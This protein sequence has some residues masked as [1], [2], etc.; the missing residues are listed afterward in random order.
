MSAIPH[1]KQ[2]FLLLVTL[3]SRRLHP[4]F[5]L[6]LFVMFSYAP[7]AQGVDCWQSETSC[8]LGYS[9]CSYL[10]IW[11]NIP[12][13]IT[14]NPL[15]GLSKIESKVVQIG[16][17]SEIANTTN[18]SPAPAGACSPKG[19]SVS[20]DTI[21]YYNYIS[22]PLPSDYFRNVSCEWT[23]PMSDGSQM[24]AVGGISIR[25][26]R[27]S[28][29]V[30]RCGNSCEI[31]ISG[32][33]ADVEPGQTVGNLRAH[34][35]CP[36]RSPEGI[37]VLLTPD[38]VDNSGGHQHIPGRRPQH[39]GTVTFTGNSGSITDANGDVTFSFT[40][41]APAGDHTI[42][43]QC[44]DNSCG[45]ASGSVWVGIRGLQ[46]IGAGP[47]ELVG[48]DGFHSNNHF[49]TSSVRQ[50]ISRVAELYH[51]KFPNNPTLRLNDGSLERGGLFDIYYPSRVVWWI[52]PH[53]QHDRGR[54]IDVRANEF[55]NPDAIPHQNYFDFE[56]IVADLG[57]FA[58]M[59][60]EFA[61]NQHYH[62]T[63]N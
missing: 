44:A 27:T 63:C 46:V 47:W 29:S 54:N 53:E 3:A 45:M 60:S 12:D 55:V 19:C 59:H 2:F 8:G 5:L 35:S 9:S 38:V 28:T 48:S 14:P 30:S 6:P 24:A 61:R 52:P 20:A 56:D 23:C 36:N 43:A 10:G 18:G 21:V 13:E 25:A 40:A 15:E 31:S 7:V 57:C 22:P 4:V 1:V 41:P 39:I 50:K 11:R 51:Q 32:L 58:R 33:P 49:L 26:F 34:V 16:S 62:V 42:T 17:S 37:A